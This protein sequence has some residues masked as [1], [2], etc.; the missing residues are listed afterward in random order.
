MLDLR[1]ISDFLL[2]LQFCVIPDQCCHGAYSLGVLLGSPFL[3]VVWT[4]LSDQSVGDQSTGL[5]L[6]L[7]P[8]VGG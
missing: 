3:Q 4:Y 1:L 6:F 8:G 5:H 7:F 2:D